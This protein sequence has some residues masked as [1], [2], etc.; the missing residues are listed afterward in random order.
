MIK[1]KKDVKKRVFGFVMVLAFLILISSSFSSSLNSSL[2]NSISNNFSNNN[3]SDD[4]VNLTEA[5]SAYN[6][7][8]K[9]NKSISELKERGLPHQE[10][11]DLLE[12]G[13]DLY[14]NRVFVIK[15]G[16]EA[17]FDKVLLLTDKIE[18]IKSDTFAVHDELVALETYL[19]KSRSEMDVNLTPAF[20][21]YSQAKKEFQDERL[22]KANSLID[23]AYSKVSEITAL[24]TK[25]KA[26]Y[27]ATAES[28]ESFFEDYGKIIA[29]ISV[30]VLI[31]LFVFKKTIKHFRIKWRISHLRKKRAILNDL[32]SEAQKDY[33]EDNQISEKEY[34]IRMKKYGEL[35]R[36]VNRQIPM[37]VEELEV[38]K[39]KNKKS[40]KSKKE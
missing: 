13:F 32:I 9:A 14:K 18:K 34:N 40:E 21:L 16:G 2:N 6:S 36:D 28:L 27:S 19:N 4:S 5:T 8:V 26:I 23:K 29:I 24:S 30:S 25:T 3:F 37:L 20:D 15:R 17:S 33:F 10:P 7:L 12:E 38:L 1:R 31:L 39:N 11:S 35:I 22:D